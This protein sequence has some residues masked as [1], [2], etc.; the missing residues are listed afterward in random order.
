[1][2]FLLAAAASPAAAGTHIHLAAL[3]T[4]RVH[5]SPHLFLRWRLPIQAHDRGNH[6]ASI[7]LPG[8][9]WASESRSPSGALCHGLGGPD[10]ASPQHS[11]QH[12]RRLRFRR[13]DADPPQPLSQDG[14]GSPSPAG[15]Q[16][17]RASEPAV[18][19]P[20]RAL[21]DAA[22]RHGLTAD[23]LETAIHSFSETQDTRDQG[24]AAYLKQQYPQAEKLLKG[25]AEK[26]GL[27]YVET[28]R[29]LGATQYERGEYRD[30]ADTFRK[31][32][33]TRLCS[34]G[35]LS[36]SMSWPTGLKPSH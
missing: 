10:L 23:Q 6:R 28:L 35:S 3:G 4:S 33:R 13:S 12:S 8:V 15:S 36:H 18:E 27:D 1:M 31:A 17:P 32:A 25:A 29:Y 19:D 26:Q 16:G 7:C 20:K 21:S 9:S 2:L 11:D 34:A 30:A 24:I 14:R 22:A 5:P